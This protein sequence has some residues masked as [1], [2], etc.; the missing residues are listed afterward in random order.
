MKHILVD[1]G[2]EGP[3][4]KEEEDWKSGMS[5]KELSTLSESEINRQTYVLLSTSLART[6]VLITCV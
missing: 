1:E 5:A 4:T 3:R 6:S 2:D